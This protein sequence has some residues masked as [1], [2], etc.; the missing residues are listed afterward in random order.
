MAKLCASS[1]KPF[2][3]S[4]LRDSAIPHFLYPMPFQ[5]VRFLGGKLGDALA[6]AYDAKTIGDLLTVSKEELQ[7][8]FGEESFWVYDIL[9][10]RDYAE[11]KARQGVKSMMA[12][13]NVRPAINAWG[14]AQHWLR[15][16]SAELALRLEEARD[17][18]PGTWPKTLVLHVKQCFEA[19]RSRQAPFP[20]SQAAGAEYVAKAGERLWR[21]LLGGEGWEAKGRG[22]EVVNVSLGFAGL[23]R[24]EE[25]QRGIEGFFA[26][27]GAAVARKASEEP[28]AKRRRTDEAGS[29]RDTP[30]PEREASALALARA[31]SPASVPPREQQQASTSASTSTPATPP[32]APSPARKGRKLSHPCS[33][34]G[35]VL[36][37]SAEDAEEQAQQLEGM[38]AEHE[39][40]HYAVELQAADEP[41]T[42]E[43]HPDG[44]EGG[45]RTGGGPG[46]KE[47][48]K[49]KKRRKE[50]EGIAAYFQKR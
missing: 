29:S 42:A 39:D 17:L 31:L 50:N 44:E 8:R 14:E 47:G 27:A 6:S 40:W 43:V 13:K 4:I 12:S 33:R 7:A 22:R 28:A 16:L 3:Q 24:K 25:G 10:G 23:E 2:G 38:K 11:V 21:E 1:R 9:R 18:E 49:K 19:P 35:Q 30:A 20:F 46:R 5:K 37:T 41:Y 48:A 32:A 36:T 45:S 26:G 15:V 34:C